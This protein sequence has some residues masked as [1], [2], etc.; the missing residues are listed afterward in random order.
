MITGILVLAL[1]LS[2][3]LFFGGIYYS[4]C[5]TDEIGSNL[6]LVRKLAA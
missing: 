1:M 2:G 6:T 5:L 4:S 3:G